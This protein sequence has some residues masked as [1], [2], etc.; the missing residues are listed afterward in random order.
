MCGSNVVT[1]VEL[2][3]KRIVKILN[4]YRPR[5][6]SQWYEHVSLPLANARSRFQLLVSGT[7]CRSHVIFVRN[8]ETLQSEFNPGISHAAIK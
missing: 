5:P 7:N 1:A 8:I 6:N 4:E 3:Y 2:Y